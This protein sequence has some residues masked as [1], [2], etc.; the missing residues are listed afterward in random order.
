[1]YN[2]KFRDQVLNNQLPDGSF[3]PAG[4]G[5]FRGTNVFGKH[6]RACL[7]ILMLEVYYRFLPATGAKTK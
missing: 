5:A 4:F 7:S 6:Y 3:K 1:R 2:E